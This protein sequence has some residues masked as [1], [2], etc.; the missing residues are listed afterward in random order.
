MALHSPDP[1]N[2]IRWEM[3]NLD[4]P[5]ACL[6]GLVPCLSLQFFSLQTVERHLGIG[7]EH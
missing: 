2:C 4:F 1:P 7:V 3:N 5:M 6:I